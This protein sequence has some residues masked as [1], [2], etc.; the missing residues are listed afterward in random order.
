M[1]ASWFGMQ[2]VTKELNCITHVKN[3]LAGG[4]WGTTCQTIEQELKG[5]VCK[6]DSKAN[7]GKCHAQATHKAASIV[8][9]RSATQKPL[10][11]DPVIEQLDKQM[12]EGGSPVSH[13]YWAGY[14]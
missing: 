9:C 5:V 12:A 10:F 3:S 13:Y 2:N 11:T 6:T 1:G 8:G 4:S 14:G 7:P